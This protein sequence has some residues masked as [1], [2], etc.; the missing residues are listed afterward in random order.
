VNNGTHLW[1][2][3][4]VYQLQ[5]LQDR[6]YVT[7]IKASD[8][9]QLDPTTGKSQ[10]CQSPISTNNPIEAVSDQTR[11]YIASPTG[12]SALQKDNG[13]VSWV[14]KGKTFGAALMQIYG[15]SLD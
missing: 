11:L 8:F 7:H 13:K 1:E 3:S 15:L 10:W 6:L 5:P 12:V 9:C 4:N 2:E 14:Y